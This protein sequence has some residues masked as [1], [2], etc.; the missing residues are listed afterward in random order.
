MRT[1]LLFAAGLG[2]FAAAAS[3][4][5]WPQWRGPNRD[6]KVA[7][8]STPRT[9]P[10]A[11]AQKWK[12]TVGLGD[13]SPAMVGNRIYVFTRQG[14]EA[15]RAPKQPAHSALASELSGGSDAQ[16]WGTRQVRE[17]L[18]LLLRFA[19]TSDAINPRHLLWLMRSMRAACSG[20]HRHHHS[21][22]ERRTNCAKRSPRSTIRKAWQSSNGTSP[23]STLLR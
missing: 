19:V 14:D 12:V 4:A 18:L 22:A 11:L 21:F 3:A 8:F 17:W 1:R 7:G 5:D 6:N 10:K 2:V 16:D 23:A 20:D 9:W 13:A 15:A